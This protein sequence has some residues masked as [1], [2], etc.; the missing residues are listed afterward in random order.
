MNK[1]WL[2]QERNEITKQ[3]LNGIKGRMMEEIV[4]LETQQAFPDKQVFKLQFAIGEFDMVV[5]DAQNATCEIYEIKHSTES[6]KEQYKH[7]IDEEKCRM[8]EHR[9]G[10]I[11][12]KVLLYRGETKEFNGIKYLNVEEYLKALQ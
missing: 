2:N 4:L 9:F 8:T 5:C 1:L 10:T 11:K 6:V 7:L 12:D 3:I